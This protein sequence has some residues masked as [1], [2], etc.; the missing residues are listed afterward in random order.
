MKR[1][2]WGVSMAALVAAGPAWASDRIGGFAVI[3]KVI[4]EGEERAPKRVQLWGA[5]TLAE[6]V[7]GRSYSAP[8]WGYLYYAAP[9]GKEAACLREW[10]DFERAA[11]TGEVIGFGVSRRL[12]E[13]GKL[14]KPAD[15]VEN[16][17]S[18]PLNFGLVKVRGDANWEP[19]RGLTTLPRLEKPGGDGKVP[20]GRVTLVVR[21]QAA[22]RLGARYVFELKEGSTVVQSSGPVDPGEAKTEWSPKGAVQAGKT[23]TWAVRAVGRG[24]KGPLVTG[25][26]QVK[27]S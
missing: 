15:K 25:T 18:Y 17:D 1:I 7:D 9:A 2:A 27:G 22:K 21:N 24:W 5:F 23:Y 20:A 13:M 10:R 8:A 11:G 26:F 4:L 3:D 16:P 19:V 14:R 6:D 12:A